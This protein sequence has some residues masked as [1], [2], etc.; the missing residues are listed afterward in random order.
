MDLDNVIPPPP[1]YDIQ[2]AMYIL[3]EL[4]HGVR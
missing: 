1:I 2:D 3:D 4:V